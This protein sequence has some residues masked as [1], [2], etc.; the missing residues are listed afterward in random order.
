MN[1]KNLNFS[2]NFKIFNEN[3]S[4]QIKNVVDNINY[5]FNKIGIRINDIKKKYIYDTQNVH[6]IL[7]D[8]KYINFNPKNINSNLG[9]F[10]NNK[11]TINQSLDC[12]FYIQLTYK[13]DECEHVNKFNIIL[14]HNDASYIFT[15]GW[16]SFPNRINV[17]NNR[18]PLRLSKNDKIDILLQNNNTPLK[19]ESLFL[20]F[21]E[22]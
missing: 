14:N 10:E 13:W 15:T 5:E 11:L 1:S 4:I 6:L 21:E 19:I 16:D 22:I 17:Y 7:N 20:I 3:K 2:K 18:I 9:Y 12:I 8:S